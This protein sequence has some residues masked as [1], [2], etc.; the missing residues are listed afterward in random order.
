MT[1]NISEYEIP[2]TSIESSYVR[3]SILLKYEG[4]YYIRIEIYTFY[5][6][7]ILY[8]IYTEAFYNF[9]FCDNFLL[10]YLSWFYV[11]YFYTRT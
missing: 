5:V 9:L 8:V 6:L 11:I 7:Y 1:V 2:S 3:N 10:F 4:I